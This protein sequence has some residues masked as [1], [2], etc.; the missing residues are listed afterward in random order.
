MPKRSRIDERLAVGEA[1][2][3]GRAEF[4]PAFEPQSTASGRNTHK[5][6]VGATD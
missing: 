3:R 2:R 5:R 4:T 1:E 6:L